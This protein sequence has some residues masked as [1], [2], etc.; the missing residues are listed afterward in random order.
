MIPSMSFWVYMISDHHVF[1]YIY[2]LWILVKVHRPCVGWTVSEG[3]LDPNNLTPRKLSSLAIG[4]NCYPVS[5]S[6]EDKQP[7]LLRV[8][9]SWQ[10][11]IWLNGRE[12]LSRQTAVMA[13]KVL[14]AGISPSISEITSCLLES[15]GK[16]QRDP[17]PKYFKWISVRWTCPSFGARASFSNG[18][19]SCR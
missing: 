2:S 10:H 17:E 9:D 6:R 14:L 8:L 18:S 7:P 1:P 13:C 11:L 12:I 3:S 19:E 15:L 5:N 16:E 4:M